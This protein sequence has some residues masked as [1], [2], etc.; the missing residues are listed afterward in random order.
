MFDKQ[1]W[2]S[3]GIEKAEAKKI[4]RESLKPISR[5][6]LQSIERFMEF[7]E[8]VR[9]AR[10]HE[11]LGLNHINVFLKYPMQEGICNIKWSNYRT[12]QGRE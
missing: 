4:S 12:Q 1:R 8:V 7:A 6:P 9:K 10:I 3:M 5:L 11:P 2:V